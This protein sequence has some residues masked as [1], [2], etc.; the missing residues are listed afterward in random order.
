MNNKILQLGI[1]VTSV[2]GYVVLS[3]FSKATAEFVTLIG[4]VLGAAFLMTHLGKQDQV[5]GQ[6]QEQTNGVLDKRI[7]DGVLKAL[8]KREDTDTL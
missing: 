6:I 7:E 8:A 5:L 2:A 4:P 1:F 3:I